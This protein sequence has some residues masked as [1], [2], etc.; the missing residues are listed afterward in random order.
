MRAYAPRDR[1][2]R[3]TGFTLVELLAVIAII[4]ILSAML[5]P[6]F[7]RVREMGRRTVC[8]SNLKQ[9]S[10]AFAMY[11]GDYD[12]HY[13]GAA[14]LQKWDKPGHW[15][16][17]AAYDSSIPVSA[18]NYGEPATL[19]DVT[20]PYNATGHQASP[21]QGALFPYVKNSQIY[22][23]PSNRDGQTK[24]LTYSMNCALGGIP[25]SGLNAADTAN[26]VLLVDEDKNNDG[27]FY[28]GATSTD[29]LTTIHNGGGNLLLADGHAK[30]YPFNKYVLDNSTTGLAN[31]LDQNAKPRFLDKGFGSNGY[32]DGGADFG[33]CGCPQKTSSGSGCP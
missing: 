27:Y 8:Q 1:F 22:I 32:Y 24:R 21:E 12:H 19:A 16:S 18:N 4:A 28:I 33:S 15:V 20:S 7:S 31:K 6:T 10:Y 23:C 26:I 14:Q 25:E 13:P 3:H 30:F 2:K 17:G 11:I 9:F 29:A 5:M